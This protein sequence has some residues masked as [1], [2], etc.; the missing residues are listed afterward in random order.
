M[1]GV[2]GESEI[3]VVRII[4]V[5]VIDPHQT[6]R[7]D[8]AARPVQNPIQVTAAELVE[9]GIDLHLHRAT[10][11]LA[12]ESDLE[13][14]G[15]LRLAGALRGARRRWRDRRRGDGWGRTEGQTTAW[16]SSAS[17]IR[18]ARRRPDRPAPIRAPRHRRGASPLGASNE[19]RTSA[20]AVNLSVD[21]PEA[22]GSATCSTPSRRT[23][24]YALRGHGRHAITRTRPAN[25]LISGAR[26]RRRAPPDP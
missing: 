2:E 5:L 13:Q 25:A 1:A 20:Q 9:I 7:I 24:N 21:V 15:L 17:A 22:N 8:D 23:Q 12:L 19:S 4:P 3:V 14:V 16:G 11:A 10:A 26:F 6:P 18:W